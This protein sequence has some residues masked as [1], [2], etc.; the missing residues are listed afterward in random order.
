L[1][2]KDYLVPTKERAMNR[3]IALIGIIICLGFLSGEA[4]IINIPADYATIQAGINASINGDTVLVAPGAYVE[5]I[6][7]GTNDILLCSEFIFSGDTM[8]IGITII[9][10][11]STNSVIY[12]PPSSNSGR[13]EYFTIRHGRGHVFGGGVYCSSRS[14]IIE[15]NIIFG[16]FAG[17]FPNHGGGIACVSDAKCIIANNAI[18]SNRAGDGGGI[19]C[20]NSDPYIL[21]N[22]I[23]DNYAPFSGEDGWG[24]GGIYLID[25]SSAIIRGNVIYRNRADMGGGGIQCARGSNALIINNVI[26]GNP[27]GSGIVMGYCDPILI[28]NIIW[29]NSPGQVDFNSSLPIITYC[30]I[31]GG[32]A[33]EGNIDANSLF[34]DTANGDFHLMSIACGDT[35]DSPCIDAGLPDSL[36]QILDCLHG[37]G[38]TRSDMGAYG[39]NN[40]GQLTGINGNSNGRIPDIIAL[41]QNYPNPFNGSTTINYFLAKAADVRIDIFDILGRKIE[42]LSEGFQSAGLHRIIWNGD[43]RPTGVYFYRI[44]AGNFAETMKMLLMK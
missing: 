15:G 26:Y 9:D 31:Q 23:S 32:F 42:T 17:D 37:L 34:R 8:D 27:I 7:F 2:F 16:N 33:G 21:N 6:N 14:A 24:G 29:N 35:A 38:T 43:S 22:I 5:N 18:L 3:F 28:N 20:S 36:D 25:N 11:D 40:S 10:G 19:F 1:G 30:D 4:R 41:S 13:L 44:Q 12:F 39:G